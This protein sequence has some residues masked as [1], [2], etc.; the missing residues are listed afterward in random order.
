MLQSELLLYKRDHLCRV[1]DWLEVWSSIFFTHDHFCEA[2]DQTF[3]GSGGI[4]FGRT[5]SILSDK[6]ERWFIKKSFWISK[7]PPLYRKVTFGQRT[8]IVSNR[9]YVKSNIWVISR[10]LPGGFATYVSHCST[11]L[12]EWY[13]LM[14]PHLFDQRFQPVLDIFPHTRLR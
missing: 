2:I 8:R 13:L 11:H 7:V 5:S 6:R 12:R 4:V 3:S 1:N 9:F 14:T 10:H